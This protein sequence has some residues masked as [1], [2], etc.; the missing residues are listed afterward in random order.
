MHQEP[1]GHLAST[2][3]ERT[4]LRMR[5]RKA[6]R[7]EETE[8]RERE[9]LTSLEHLDPAMPDARYTLFGFPSPMRRNREREKS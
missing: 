8:K 1:K 7:E 4:Y 2:W 6:S 5:S 9:V 3:R